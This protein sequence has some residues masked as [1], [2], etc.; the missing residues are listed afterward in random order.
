M[1][2]T[3]TYLSS[4][5]LDS[6]ESIQA[7][8][9]K[10]KTHNLSHQISG[11]LLHKNGNFMQILEGLEEQVDAIY[12]KIIKDKR[13][14]Q[15]IKLIDIPIPGRLFQEYKASFSLINS[16]SDFTEL[17]SYINWLKLADSSCA[18]KAVGVLENFM[19]K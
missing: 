14:H 2:K 8:F 1:L 7:L 9:E 6:I 3:I 17:N 12:N 5:K 15:I 11:I 13:H 16:N 10:A 19:K 4:S 18:I